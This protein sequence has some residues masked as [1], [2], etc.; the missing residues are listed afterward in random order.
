MVNPVTGWSE[1][2]QYNDKQ[3]VAIAKLVETKW[4]VRYIWPVDIMHD[5]GVE[6]FGRIFKNSLIE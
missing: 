3:V 5:R 1:M 6:L 4:L 2:K